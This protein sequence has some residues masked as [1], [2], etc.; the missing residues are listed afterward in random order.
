MNKN[1]WIGVL[2]LTTLL[3]AV[4][5][6]SKPVSFG[7]ANPTGPTHY[8]METFNQGLVGGVHNQFVV[9]NI[10]QV[11]VGG[12]LATSTTGTA[13]T[14]APA[15]LAYSTMLMTL[16]TASATLTLP[17]ATTLGSSF[18][19]NIGDR[20]DMIIYNAT[21]TSGIVLTV[22]GNTGVTLKSTTAN[23]QI[24]YGGL[25]NLRIIRVSASAFVAYITA[26]I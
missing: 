24:P 15:D 14:V 21:T 6:F 19:P 1:I 17:L 12:A 22:A 18:L 2:V 23:A 8:Q 26:S 25:G 5:Y 4:L 13:V 11:T 16:N 10:G 7:S 3:F 9:S 20:M